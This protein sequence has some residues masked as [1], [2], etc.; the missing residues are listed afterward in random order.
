ML[1]VL[2][3]AANLLSV[4]ALRFSGEDEKVNLETAFPEYLKSGVTSHAVITLSKNHLNEFGKLQLRL[5]SEVQIVEN[6][7]SRAKFSRKDDLAEWSWTALPEQE[8]I[9]I[10]LGLLS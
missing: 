10:S 1:R 9:T 2:F 3:I 4:L 5:P 8:E 7:G 6:D